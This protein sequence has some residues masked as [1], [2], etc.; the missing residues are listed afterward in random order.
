MCACVC[1]SSSL[2]AGAAQQAFGSRTELGNRD[3]TQCTVSERTPPRTN[4]SSVG[5]WTAPVLRPQ[6]DPH[7]SGET[8]AAAALYPLRAHLPY[9]AVPV[10]LGSLCKEIPP[11]VRNIFFVGERVELVWGEKI[12][13]ARECAVVVQCASCVLCNKLRSFLMSRK[14]R[15]VKINWITHTKVIPS[16]WKRGLPDTF[17]NQCAIFSKIYILA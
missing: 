2:A 3:G 17:T 12:S 4:V 14:K 15:K 1:S 7:C 9:T 10:V 16:R 5:E 13:P 11:V 8:G 6:R